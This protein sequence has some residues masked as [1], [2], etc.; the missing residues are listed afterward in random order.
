MSRVAHCV[1]YR[2]DNFNIDKVLVTEVARPPEFRCWNVNTPCN[3]VVACSDGDSVF[4]NHSTVD[5][6]L[7]IGCATAIAIEPSVHSE[8]CAFGRRILTENAHG[9]DSYGPGVDE[10]NTSPDTSWVGSARPRGIL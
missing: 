8:M 5:G 4:C 1:I 10:V 3:V 9:I 7:D 6:G 2:N